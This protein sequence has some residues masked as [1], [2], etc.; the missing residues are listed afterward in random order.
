MLVTLPV[1]LMEPFILYK[2]KPTEDHQNI[3][4][5]RLVPNTGLDIVML[6]AHMISSL[7]MEKPIVKIGKMIKVNM[8]AVVLNSMF[9]KQTNKQ[10]PSLPILVL[11]Q[12]TI[13]VQEKIV[14]M[15]IIDKM[16][17]VIKTVLI[18]TP[19]ETATRIFMAQ[20][21]TIKLIQQN[22]SKL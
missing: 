16:E 12:A 22:L 11:N 6:S 1:V 18:L 15:E 3:L 21:L 2:W 8:G 9:G 19:L 13:D 5:T 20:D 14:E 17:F 4:P 10:M 7:F